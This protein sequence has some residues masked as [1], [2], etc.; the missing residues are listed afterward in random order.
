MSLTSSRL[1]G[2][3]LALR[4]VLWNMCGTEIKFSFH[5]HFISCLL[6]TPEMCVVPCCCW[7]QLVQMDIMSSTHTMPHEQPI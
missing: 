1:A 7:G 3:G 5:K 2:N 6:V 4:A